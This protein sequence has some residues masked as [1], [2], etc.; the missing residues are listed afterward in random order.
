MIDRIFIDELRVPVSEVVRRRVRL[1]KAGRE[2]KRLSPFNMERTLSFYV[3]DTKQ[4][5]HDFSSDKHGDVFGFVMQ[6]Y[7]IGFHEAVERCA[8]IAGKAVSSG[9][10]AS[11]KRLTPIQTASPQPCSE[12]LA[13]WREAVD[14]FG[15]PVTA[16]LERRRMPL[17]QEAAGEAVRF[18]P[19]CKFGLQRVPCRIAL[20]RDIKTN[21]PL[22]IQRTA[23]DLAGNKIKVDDRDRMMLGPVAE[24]GEKRR[25]AP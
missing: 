14:P 12:A 3:N 8:E 18:H 5:W 10:G 4:R 22:A 2:W 19:A 17:P 24:A 15:T 23:L 1:Q 20:V 6:V 25:A 7:G 9:T 11:A 21:Q 13:L 16:H